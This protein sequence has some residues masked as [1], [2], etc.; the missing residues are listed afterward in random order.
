MKMKN[1]NLSMLLAV[2]AVAGLASATVYGRIIPSAQQAKDHAAAPEASPVIT[3]EDGDWVLTLGERSGP[4]EIPAPPAVGP[5]LEVDPKILPISEPGLEHGLA[6]DN[7]PVIDLV[8]GQWVLSPSSMTPPAVLSA[9]EV[10]SKI[11]PI[12][13]PGLEHGL[14]PDNSPV[15]DLVDG[16]WVLSPPSMTP[17][18]VGEALFSAADSILSTDYGTAR[19]SLVIPEPATLLLLGLGGLAIRRRSVH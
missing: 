4:P 11:L 17:P 10:E 5:A 14:A 1:T 16:Q 3:V 18:A 2:L 13:E 15:I 9:L 19:S 6:P 8:E 7:S 12:S